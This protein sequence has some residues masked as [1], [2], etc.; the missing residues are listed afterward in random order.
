MSP[1]A[2]VDVVGRDDPPP[3]EEVVADLPLESIEEGRWA[4]L[5]GGMTSG[6]PS[7]ALLLR[8]SEGWVVYQTSLAIL[9]AVVAAGRGAQER[10]SG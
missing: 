5:E 2:R 1:E 3:W 6:N 4:I 8:T 9:E 7:V 10:W